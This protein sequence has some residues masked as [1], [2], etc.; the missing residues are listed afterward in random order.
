M[1]S[2]DQGDADVLNI[3]SVTYEDGSGSDYFTQ[4]YLQAME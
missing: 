3:T 4:N 1:K 2:A